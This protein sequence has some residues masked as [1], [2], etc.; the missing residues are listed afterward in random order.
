VVPIDTVKPEG[1]SAPVA[2][3]ST[4]RELEQPESQ[5]EPAPPMEGMCGID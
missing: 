5:A 4:M 2:V 3:Y 1:D